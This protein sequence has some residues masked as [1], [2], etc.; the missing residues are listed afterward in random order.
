MLM[1]R[2]GH[3]RI[4]LPSQIVDLLLREQRQ[5]W[6]PKVQQSRWTTANKN[7]NVTEQGFSY[8]FS[9]MEVNIP[10]SLHTSKHRSHDVH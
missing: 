1:D 6:R 4:V 3:S 10:E 7:K 8:L 9:K 2:T 5:D